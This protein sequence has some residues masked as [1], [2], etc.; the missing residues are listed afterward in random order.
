MPSVF[1][2]NVS[3]GSFDQRR[4][5]GAQVSV[6]SV[7]RRQYAGFGRLQTSVTKFGPFMRLS[8]SA[9]QGF[10]SRSI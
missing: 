8:L 7:S 3:L 1:S 10:Q 2:N 6:T 4:H 5:V 9:P